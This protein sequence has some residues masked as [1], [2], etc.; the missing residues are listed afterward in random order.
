MTP[1]CVGRILGPFK[2]QGEVK[3]ISLTSFPESRFTMGKTLNFETKDNKG[4]LT[5]E[6]SKISGQEIIIKFTEI[7]S[8][9][10]ALNFKGA[11]LFAEKDDSLLKN[12]QYYFIDLE[13]CKIINQNNIE[14]GT[15]N[16]V[17]EYP[18]QI[19]LEVI[20]QK[21]KIIQIPFVEAFIKK[22]DI[23]NKTIIV[24]TIGGML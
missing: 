19:T 13:G 7:N 24:N 12:N 11:L 1:L 2:V 14:V 23:K 16:K 8:P 15:V 21:K 22:V 3:I 17:L 9:E 4:V 5:I 10:E 20:T 18:A 6:G